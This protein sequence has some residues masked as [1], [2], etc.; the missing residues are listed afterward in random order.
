MAVKT[1]Q[2]VTGTTAVELTGSDTFRGGENAD[3]GLSAGGGFASTV[4][5]RVS[6]NTYIGGADVTPGNG[7]LIKADEAISIELYRGETIWGVL[8]TGSGTAYV[9]RSGV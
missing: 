5:I 7:L 2:V 4:T 8:G 1:A 3:G 6:V 9:L